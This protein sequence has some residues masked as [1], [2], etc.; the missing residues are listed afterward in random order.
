MD[1]L[2]FLLCSSHGEGMFVVCVVKHGMSEVFYKS[3]RK[4][5]QKSKICCNGC[6]LNSVYMGERP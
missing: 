5:S 4:I 1:A 3:S 2:A 6:N